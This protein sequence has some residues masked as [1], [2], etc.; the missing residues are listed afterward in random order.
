MREFVY[1]SKR[2]VTTGNFKDLMQA[3]RMDIV[4][5]IVIM[6]FFLSNAQRTN[7]KLNLFFYG[8]P[9]PPKHLEIISGENGL[10]ASISK[11]DII[12]L[13]KRMLYKA[14]KERKEVFPGCFVSSR[15]LPEYVSEL[16]EEGKEM[17]LLEGNGED[18]R[19]V[20]IVKDPVF[21]LGDHEGFP[22]LEKKKI[23]KSAEK[24][25]VGPNTYFASQTMSILQ[26]E[27]DRRRIV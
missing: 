4:S 21:F 14:G 12:G 6:S 27:L 20:E 13:I 22:K 24:I 16:E 8:P 19:N 25:T 18:I 5:H 9:N 11:K 2:A 17:F 10:D 3:G 23:K 1:F 15:T 26:N 7:V